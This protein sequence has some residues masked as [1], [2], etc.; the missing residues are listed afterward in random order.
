MTDLM[1]EARRSLHLDVACPACGAG[2]S[3]PCRSSSGAVRVQVHA[4]RKRPPVPV[5][6]VQPELFTAEQDA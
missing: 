6:W 3:L 1:A 2:F 5:R 4:A